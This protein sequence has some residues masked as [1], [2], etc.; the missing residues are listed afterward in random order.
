MKE[1]VK[2]QFSIGDESVYLRIAQF[3]KGLVQFTDTTNAF[4]LFIKYGPDIRYNALWKK[5]L[6]WNGAYWEPDEGYLIHDRG[7]RMIRDLYRELLQTADYRERQDI[8]KH[9]LRLLPRYFMLRV[10]CSYLP[11]AEC[12]GFLRRFCLFVFTLR[13]SPYRRRWSCVDIT[14]LSLALCVIIITH[15]I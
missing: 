5:W 15:I 7:L 14:V 1:P 3:E 4:R 12:W 11:R 2:T 8:E 10:K 6:A 13:G 9:G